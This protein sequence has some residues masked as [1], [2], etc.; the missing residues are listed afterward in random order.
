MSRGCDSTEAENEDANSSG[1]D[2]E[3]TPPPHYRARLPSS[4][5]NFGSTRHA[6]IEEASRMLNKTQQSGILRIIS[7]TATIPLH[8]AGC[9]L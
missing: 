5:S 9:S 8:Y 4:P 6:W 1:S 3:W 7:I 2:P